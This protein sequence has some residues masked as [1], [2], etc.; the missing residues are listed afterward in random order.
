MYDGVFGGLLRSGSGS[1]LKCGVLGEKNHDLNGV[2]SG[3]GDHD[4]VFG[5]GPTS[6]SFSV[7][8]GVGAVDI[9]IL[10]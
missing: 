10:S 3:R 7:H 4:G 6:S 1:A 5:A 9:G 2:L 8:G